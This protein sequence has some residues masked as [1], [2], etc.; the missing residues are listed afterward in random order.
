MMLD[1]GFGNIC[2]S[3]TG[4]HWPFLLDEDKIP[5]I[6]RGHFMS[7]QLDYTTSYNKHDTLSGSY[8]YG[9]TL[10]LSTGNLIG[11]TIK[12]GRYFSV[13]YRWS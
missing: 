6:L 2:L 13:L 7:Q 5:Q 11:T 3:D 8:Q 1:K 9:G 10:S 4:I 12:G